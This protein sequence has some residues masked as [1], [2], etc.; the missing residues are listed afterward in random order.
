MLGKRDKVLVAFS[1]GPDSSL[2]LLL[3]TELKRKYSISLCAGHINHILRGKESLADEKQAQKLCKELK[4]PC[5][6][7]R[8]NVKK[9]KKR[10]ES[11]EEAARRIRYEALEEIARGFGANK[12]ALGH[13]INDQ[14]ETILFRIIRGTGED[15]L[16]GIPPVRSLNPDIKIIRP[17][18]EIGRREI[19][20]YLKSKNIKPR[21]DSSNFDMKFSRNRIRHELIP[22]LEKY[23]PQIK[24]S[25]LRISQISRENSEY[26]GQDTRKILKCISAHLPDAI[27]I[28]L[29]KLLVYPKFLRN[30]ILREAIKKFT[31]EPHNLNYSNLEEIEKIIDSRKANLVLYLPYG[32]KIIKEYGS[33][34]IRKGKTTISPNRDSYYYVFEGQGEFNIPEIKKI[35]HIDC[36]S[37]KDKSSL[38][39]DDSSQI[40][41]DADKIKFPLILRTR[42]GGDRFYPFG[43]KKE[44]KLK[45][46]FI[47]EKIPLKER[48]RIPILVTKA[49]KILWIVGYRR[50]NLGVI[51]KETSQIIRIT[52]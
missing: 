10:G 6:I 43:M 22:Y 2:L 36:L 33:L 47:D 32:V 17:L 26:I 11:I 44:K 9:L 49:G 18:I 40:Y 46:F 20:E 14:I 51:T 4:V 8:K 16:G 24:D 31:G 30:H 37:K 1:G 19:E 28:D 50:S 42:K 15:G 29:N 39:F 25:L 3:L 34:F 52:L 38:K 35:I 45:D 5:K 41:L 23:N 13:N 48:D 12:I 21:V 7:A 27:K